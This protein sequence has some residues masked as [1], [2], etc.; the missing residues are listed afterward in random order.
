MTEAKNKLVKSWLT[1]AKHDL[2]AAYKLSVGDDPVLDYAVYHC[3]QAAEKALKGFL[4]YHDQRVDK[5]HDLR[6]LILLISEIDKAFLA[7]Q[8]VGFRLTPL[9]TI[10]RYPGDEMQ[11]DPARF[12]EAFEDAQTIYYFVLSKLPEEVYP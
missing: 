11:P 1:K 3:Q 5:T 2:N 4:V 12:S 10:Y 8:E 6:S 9:A 7:Y